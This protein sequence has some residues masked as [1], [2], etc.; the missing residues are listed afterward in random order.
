[1]HALPYDVNGGKTKKPLCPA[2]GKA[3]SGRSRRYNG[4]STAIGFS[5]TVVLFSP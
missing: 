1:M 3:V 5:V 2:T 4:Y